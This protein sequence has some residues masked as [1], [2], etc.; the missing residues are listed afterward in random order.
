MIVVDGE[1][2]RRTISGE[3]RRLRREAGLSQG[4]LAKLIGSHRPI[5]A[6]IENGHHVA[7]LDTCDR[8]ARACGSDI[9]QVAFVVDVALGLR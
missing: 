3:L 5:V 9:E 1:L 6:R 8:I 7:S 4:E 2:L